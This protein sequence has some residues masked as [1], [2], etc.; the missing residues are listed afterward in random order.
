MQSQ[1]VERLQAICMEIEKHNRSLLRGMIYRFAFRLP[2][3]DA[4]DASDRYEILRS[5]QLPIY[6]N[7][8]SRFDFSLHWV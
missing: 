5:L 6:V 4:S 8:D 7:T 1:L 2:S 3:F